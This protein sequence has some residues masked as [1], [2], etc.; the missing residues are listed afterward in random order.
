MGLAVELRVMWGGWCGIRWK[1]FT[2]LRLAFIGF[3]RVEA[4]QSNRKRKVDCS[5][6]GVGK[7]PILY[8]VIHSTRTQRPWLAPCFRTLDH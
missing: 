6:H 1:P 7:A 3:F 4:E 8:A 5:F 2:G